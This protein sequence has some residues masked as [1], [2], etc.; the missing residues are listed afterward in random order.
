LLHRETLY[1]RQNLFL[2]LFYGLLTCFQDDWDLLHFPHLNDLV[3]VHV[4]HDDFVMV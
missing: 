4:D 1:R 3:K 2:F